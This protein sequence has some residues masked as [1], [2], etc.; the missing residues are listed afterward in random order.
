MATELKKPVRSTRTLP[1]REP[2]IISVAATAGLAWRK[3]TL[4]LLWT[5]ADKFESTVE[6][7]GETY[8][9]RESN[10]GERQIITQN[11]ALANAE[12][13]RSI[14]YVKGYITD[15]FGA[16]NAKAY[17]AKFGI[18]KDKRGY[19]IP[20]DNDSRLRSLQLLVNAL[21]EFEMQDCKYGKA[22]W[23]ELY[24]RYAQASTEAVASDSTTARQVAEKSELRKEIITT[25]NALISLVKANYPR[26]WREELR[27]WGFQKEKY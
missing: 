9:R 27:E 25:L 23:N 7:Y 2:D 4:T 20:A 24:L 5:T 19:S 14:K 12:I 26:T 3:S 18:V 22:Y 17:Y 11:R 13:D 1:G 6:T 8:D 16:T 21:D 10:R 15:K